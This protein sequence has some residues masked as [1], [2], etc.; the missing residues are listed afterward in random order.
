MSLK[1]KACMST[2]GE[3][4]VTLMLVH[5]LH[6]QQRSNGKLL[7]WSSGL[8]RIIQIEKGQ[9]LCWISWSIYW[10]RRRLLWLLVYNMVKL[11]WLHKC[12]IT[13]ISFLVLMYRFKILIL[14]QLNTSILVWRGPIWQSDQLCGTQWTKLNATQS[15]MIIKRSVF[16]CVWMKDDEVFYSLPTWYTTSIRVLSCIY[17]IR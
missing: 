12:N 15:M 11:G 6:W 8:C 7:M 17:S 10:L 14:R 13:N 4:D 3:E 9:R 16:F 1:W 5:L 2:K